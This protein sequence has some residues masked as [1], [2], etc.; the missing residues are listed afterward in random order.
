MKILMVCLGN[1]CRSPIAE[2]ILRQ[3]LKDGG[4]SHV[5]TDSAGT[6]AFHV[7]EAPDRRMRATAKQ[8]GVDIDDLRARQFVPA[9]FDHFDIIYAMDQSNY[10]N[11]MS[12]AQT[13]DEKDKVKMILNEVNPSSNE[14]VPDPYYGGDEG[15]QHVFDLLDEA[16]DVIIEKYVKG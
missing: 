9:D 2:G 6:S 16:T 5:A 11:I 15:F 7:G 10:N 13:E 1:I 14:A 3:K 12:L 4:F 8:N